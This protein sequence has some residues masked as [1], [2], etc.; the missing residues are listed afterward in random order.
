MYRRQLGTLNQPPG[1]SEHFC[2]SHCLHGLQESSRHEAWTPLCFLK[3]PLVRADLQEEWLMIE[4]LIIPRVQ[5]HSRAIHFEC[6]MLLKT[7]REEMVVQRLGTVKITTTFYIYCNTALTPKHQQNKLANQATFY[8]SIY[9]SNY[10]WADLIFKWKSL[11]FC[12]YYGSWLRRW[13]KPCKKKVR[14]KL[15]G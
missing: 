6:T 2:Y 14:T 5:G 15:E 8:Y 4:L 11:K 10:S 3:M 13:P 12:R 7:F 9:G 1:K